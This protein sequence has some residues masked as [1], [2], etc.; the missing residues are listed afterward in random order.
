MISSRKHEILKVYTCESEG[1]DL[2][3]IGKL[4]AGL[5]NGRQAEVEFVARIEMEWTRI[6][7]RIS[8]YQVWSVGLMATEEK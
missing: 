5:D 7:L 4:M 3:A 2:L 6:G 1:L 8:S